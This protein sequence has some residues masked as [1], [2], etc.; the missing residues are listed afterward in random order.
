VIHGDL[1][2]GRLPYGQI[3]LLRLPVS[4]W[5]VFLLSLFLYFDYSRTMES[6]TP[7]QVTRYAD[8]FAALGNEARLRILRLLLTA[9]PDGLV[10]RDIQSELEIPNSTLSHHLERLKNE[11][12]L[13]VRRDRQFL[14]Y[15]ANTTNL[16]ALTQFLFAECCSRNQAINPRDILVELETK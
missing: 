11:G 12:L 6:L 15:S 13:E 1:P 5:V 16:G 3:I 10:V 9:H 4:M 7:R 2:P 14:W 8:M